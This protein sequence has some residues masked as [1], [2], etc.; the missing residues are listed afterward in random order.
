MRDVEADRVVLGGALRSTGSSREERAG[1]GVVGVKGVGDHESVQ[2]G[3]SPRLRERLPRGDASFVLV[4][5]VVRDVR[6]GVGVVQAR[7]LV[8]HEL[9][10][11]QAHGGGGNS[12]GRGSSSR[13]SRWGSCP[14]PVVLPDHVVGDSF[15]GNGPWRRGWG[16][17][18]LRADQ[19]AE[20]V[21]GAVKVLGASELLDLAGE[22]RRLDLRLEGGC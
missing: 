9:L 17:C 21:S 15:R 11:G 14:C 2:E 10:R 6:G 7:R 4:A 13:G 19:P 20:V 5:V 8:H 1:V 22:E 3:C 18:Q 12:Q 16:T